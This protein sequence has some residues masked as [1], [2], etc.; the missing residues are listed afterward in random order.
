METEGASRYLAHES[1][2]SITEK[3]HQDA[4]NRT[5][6][7]STAQ[8]GVLAQSP[9][10]C[11]SSGWSGMLL[12][13]ALI[14]VARFGPDVPLWDDY[15]VIPQLA[16]VQPVTPQWLWS[17]H[18]EHRIPLAR[19]ISAGDI[20]PDRGRPARGDVSDRGPFGRLRG[21]LADPC[22]PPRPFGGLGMRMPSCRSLF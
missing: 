19:L 8:S 16:G 2:Y 22:G 12:V 14:Y 1:C 15:E 5:D 4:S 6:H 3:T 7:R 10:K 18:S 17:Q 11:C 13:V 20:S 9:G 21:G